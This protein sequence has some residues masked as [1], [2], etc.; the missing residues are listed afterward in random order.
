[1][2]RD[3]LRRD[4]HRRA[5]RG[6]L[7]RVAAA[8]DERHRTPS[9][10]TAT[11]STVRIPSRPGFWPQ[12]LNGDSRFELEADRLVPEHAQAALVGMTAHRDQDTSPNTMR[13]RSMSAGAP[14][15]GR[16]RTAAPARAAR[17]S[18]RRRARPAR[19]AR[20]VTRAP[21]AHRRRASRSAC[22]WCCS[23]A[24]TACR[25]SSPSRRRAQGPAAARAPAPQRSPSRN[26]PRIVNASN[27]SAA[28]RRPAGRS[29]PARRSPAARLPDPHEGS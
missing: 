21:A 19:R 23:S 16:S 27:V 18:R 25:G 9:P 10:I 29:R 4:Q 26:S 28:A 8:G 24:G 17:T 2:D 12:M 22:R 13:T 14:R 6:D 11:L 3:H 5:E 20:A 1:M 15:R 7:E